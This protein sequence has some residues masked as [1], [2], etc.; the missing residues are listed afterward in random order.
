VDYRDSVAAL[1][2]AGESVLYPRSLPDGWTPT[3][4]RW[5]P[6]ERPVWALSFLTDEGRF[7]G[8][9]AEDDD[10]DDLLEVYVDERAEQGDDV[11]FAGR[12]W[13]T[14]SDEGG[15]HAFATSVETDGGE[16]TVLVY[17]SAPVEDLRALA[18]SLTSDPIS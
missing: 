13:T 10:L 14:W 18:E 5:V 8:V 7:A 3:A 17:G 1:Q 6:G 2:G 4:V 9:Q 16:Q 12:T 11:S 15:D